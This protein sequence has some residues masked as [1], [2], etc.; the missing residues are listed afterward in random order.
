M[1][2]IKIGDI[3]IWYETQKEKKQGEV[4]GIEGDMAN[5]FCISESAVYKKP[6][7]KLKKVK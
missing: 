2:D 4:Y 3:V 6:L 1:S 7:N 5:I